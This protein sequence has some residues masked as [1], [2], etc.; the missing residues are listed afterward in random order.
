VLALIASYR[1]EHAANGKVLDSRQ[2]KAGFTHLNCLRT[3]VSIFTGREINFIYIY[4]E[5]REYAKICILI[6]AEYRQDFIM[7]TDN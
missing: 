6:Y 5:E 3:Y 7:D 1:G 2:I 4:E